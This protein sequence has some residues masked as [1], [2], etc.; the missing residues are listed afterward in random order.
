MRR[1]VIELCLWAPCD[2]LFLWP[3]IGVCALGDMCMH[4]ISAVSMWVRMPSREGAAGR[5][6]GPG[7][8]RKVLSVDLEDPSP[9]YY[10]IP[11]LGLTTSFSLVHHQ[12]QPLTNARCP[13]CPSTSRSVFFPPK[14]SPKS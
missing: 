11:S 5:G 13:L 9:Q 8:F 6:P 3:C 7:V 14:A 1:I 4:Y 10:Q 12:D 2:S